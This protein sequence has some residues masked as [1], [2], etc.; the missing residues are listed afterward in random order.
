MS[1]QKEQPK[2]ESKTVAVKSN[3]TAKIPELQ[4][5]LKSGVQFGHEAK[6]WNPKMRDYIFAKRDGIHIIDLSKTLERLQ[7]A[8][9]FLAEAAKTGEVLFV[10][11]KRQASD[12]VKEAAI[13]AGAHFIVQRWPGGLLTN[14]NVIQKSLKH[15][16]E[17]ELEFEK[18]VE[19]RTKFEIAMMKKEWEK[20]SRIYEGIKTMA[21][22]PQAIVIVDTNYE[23]NVIREA[24]RL[25]IPVVALIDTNCNPN[26]VEYPIP[27]NDDAIRSIKLI[28]G[29]LAQ[30]VKAASATPKIKHVLKDYSKYEVR[31]IKSEEKEEEV[32]E[33]KL[34]PAVAEPRR[35]YTPEPPKKKGK[36]AGKGLLEKMQEQ[37]ETT[38]TA[39]ARKKRVNS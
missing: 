16:N 3:P 9:D 12:I 22:F 31:I 39:S 14:F 24:K 28:I 4:E 33:L 18:G 15:Y 25:K 7:T 20:M 36:D 29:L 38:K 26:I 32:V 11:T 19:D 5:F 23:R 35:I 10:G 34:E 30:T 37:K 2:A 17:L 13:D 8:L 27:A 6:K 1:T 21:R